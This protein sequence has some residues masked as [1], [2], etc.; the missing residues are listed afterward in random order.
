MFILGALKQTNLQ[1]HYSN[2]QNKR[3]YLNCRQFTIRLCTVL[4]HHSKQRQLQ[5][6][7]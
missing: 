6:C 5:I 7:W 3:M 4:Q 1:I 2:A